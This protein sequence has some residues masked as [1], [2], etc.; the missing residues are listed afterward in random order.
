MCMY[1][2]TL[3]ICISTSSINIIKISVFLG[4]APPDSASSTHR[5]SLPCRLN[6]S[7]LGSKT[8]AINGPTQ[9]LMSLNS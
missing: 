5:F 8:I 1:I 3:H 4:G 9:L 2:S 6:V 7:M